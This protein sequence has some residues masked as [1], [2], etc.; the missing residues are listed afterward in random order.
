MPRGERTGAWLLI[1]AA[2]STWIIRWVYTSVEQLV[3]GQEGH[4]PVSL[5]MGISLGGVLV[6]IVLA[7]VGL[8]RLARRLPDASTGS[9]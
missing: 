8:T 3:G 5:S 2:A 9:R 6:G 7:V 1:L 4:L